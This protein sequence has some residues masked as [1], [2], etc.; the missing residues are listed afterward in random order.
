MYLYCWFQRWWHSIFILLVLT[1]VAF[2]FVLLVPALLARSS[3][4][5]KH[6]QRR[7]IEWG[8]RRCFSWETLPETE[9]FIRSR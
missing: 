9:G 3:D 4:I 6:I 2:S 1:S 8:F 7:H 5:V